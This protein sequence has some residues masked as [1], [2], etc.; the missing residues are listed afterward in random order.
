MRALTLDELILLPQETAV[1]RH[2]D[3]RNW[4]Y[5]RW[6]LLLFLPA[7]VVGTVEFYERRTLA[8]GVAVANL[9][10]LS[11]FFLAR[12]TRFF[13]ANFRSLLISFVALECLALALFLEAPE[14]TLFVTALAFPALAIGLRLRPK[15]HVLLAFLFLVCAALASPL[16][17]GLLWGEAVSLQA[18]AG[19]AVA[20][21]LSAAIAL[22]VT[23]TRRRRFLE[24]WRHAAIRERERSRLRGEVDDARKIQ[25]S[26]LPRSAPDLPWLDVA[27]VSL[28]AKEVGGDYFDYF[29]LTD[30][31]LAIVIG[32]VAGHGV[33]SGL[34]LYGLRSCLYMLRDELQ[35]PLPVLAR[36]DRMV[37]EAG[38]KR[39]LVTFQV[40]IVDVG[41]RRIVVASAGHPPA[42]HFAAA[43]GEVAELGS[44]TLPLG[45]R[46]GAQPAEQ[47][48]ALAAGDLLVFYSDGLPEVIDRHGEHYGVE[49]VTRALRR[50]ADGG[51]AR[52]VRDALLNSVANFKGDVE[53]PDD[54]TLVVARIVVPMQSLP[55][56]PAAPQ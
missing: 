35:R 7:A 50:A 30:D 27:S 1:Q 55:S 41:A 29:K 22:A 15:E 31:C 8:T 12:N 17:L 33:A 20:N 2:F 52:Q 49:R 40:G 5:L 28:P 43:T 37:R 18:M 23:R 48:V 14:R 11:V 46:L 4:L 53:Q 42:L 16:G 21:L 32:D 45:T 51:S 44:A 36:L 24:G 54:L 56:T 3:G 9:V 34:M 38:P 39:M 47:G 10:L 6:L 25:L 13:E 19:V 26:I